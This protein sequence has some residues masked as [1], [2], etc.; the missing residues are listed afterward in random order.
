MQTAGAL[1]LAEKFPAESQSFTTALASPIATAPITT[2]SS[3]SGSVHMWN[4]GR[5]WPSHHHES[6][7]MVETIEFSSCQ[8]RSSQAC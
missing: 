7:E 4:S 5:S 2:I 8:G 1:G 3:P 6:N